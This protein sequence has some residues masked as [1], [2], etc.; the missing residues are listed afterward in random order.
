M[1]GDEGFELSVS[2]SQTQRDNQITL[3]PEF[4]NVYVPD[5]P[6]VDVSTHM[7]YNICDYH[8]GN[9]IAHTL[10]PKYKQLQ[11]L[12]SHSFPAVLAI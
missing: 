7:A 12:V 9:S 1:V 5:D 3:I 4:F 6:Y 11:P 10:H 8:L 2:A